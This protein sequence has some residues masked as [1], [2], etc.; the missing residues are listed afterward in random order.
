MTTTTNR[1]YWPTK[2]GAVAFEP[3]WFSGHSTAFIYIN[4][5]IGT[6]PPNMSHPM[7]P[8]FQITGP[9]NNAYQGRPLCIPQVGMPANL[10]LTAGTNATI[11]IVEATKHGAALFTVS[12][13]LPA[14]QDKLS[15]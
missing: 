4:L 3:G 10:S 9:T 8:V 15:D 13:R 12:P 5:G 2:G 6:N 11:Q 14:P 7:V 1:T